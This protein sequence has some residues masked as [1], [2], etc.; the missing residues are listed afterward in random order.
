MRMDWYDETAAALSEVSGIA[1]S[2]LE[3]SEPLRTELLDLARIASHHSGQRINAP[4]ICYALGIAVARGVPLDVL[5][6]AIRER[7]GDV[8]T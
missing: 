8:A 4:F 5:A 2:D 7:A 3:L 1:L 6:R